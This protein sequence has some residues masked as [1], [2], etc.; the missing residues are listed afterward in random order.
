MKLLL[1]SNST[2]PGEE[3]LTYPLA[4]IK[5]FL[6]VKSAVFI[7]FAAV[8][9]TFDEFTEIVAKRFKSLNIE[10]KGVHTFNDKIAA[11]ENAEAIVVGGGN[12]FHLVSK[13]EEFGLMDVIRKKAQAGTPY[14]GW[15]AGSNLACPTIRTT[16]DMPI[17]EPKSFNVL[18]LIPHQINPHYT[19]YVDKNHGGETRDDRINEFTH[20]NKDMYVLGLREACMIK[21]VDNEIELIGDKSL[22]LF[23][24]NNESKELSAEEFKDFWNKT[25]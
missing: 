12:T 16:N 24:Y 22:K 17:V 6:H 13:L 3:F 19:D 11:L 2:N 7:P 20:A 4:E 25:K 9:P 21:I 18:N 15:S 14:V 8:K 10:V 23:K 1:I 5:K